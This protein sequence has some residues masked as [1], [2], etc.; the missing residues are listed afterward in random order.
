MEFMILDWIQT[1]RTPWLDGFMVFVSSLGNFGAVWIILAV[2]LLLLPKY[3]R[4]GALLACALL[5][6]LV[7]CNVLLKPLVARPRPYDLNQMMEYLIDRPHGWSFPSGHTAASFAAATALL[8]GRSRLWIPCGILAVL[9]AFS[10]L[11]L[12]VHYPSDVLG[13]AVVGL[14]AAWAGSLL[15]KWLCQRRKNIAKM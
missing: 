14:A 8:L 13:G 11:Y 10:R 6:D 15:E 2:V 9:I 5:I 7:V 12:Y 3:R 1:L 4:V